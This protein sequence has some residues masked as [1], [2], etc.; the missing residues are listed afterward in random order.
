MN[1]RAVA[2]VDLSPLD[3]DEIDL[4]LDA[5]AEA[6]AEQILHAHALAEPERSDAL[7][8]LAEAHRDLRDHLDEHRD[9][10]LADA[11]E[12]DAAVR[13][14]LDDSGLDDDVVDDYFDAVESA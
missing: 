4:P 11:A 13:D 2:G 12:F 7:A 6:L 14:A 5:R 9:L 8:A 10:T 1:R 3:P